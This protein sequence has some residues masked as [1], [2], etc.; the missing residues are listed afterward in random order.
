MGRFQADGPIDMMI[1]FKKEF[2]SLMWVLIVLRIA[3]MAAIIRVLITNY[4]SK[5]SERG[6]YP[7]TTISKIWKSLVVIKNE[8]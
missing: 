6:I 8:Q 4:C 7:A 5:Y 2:P 1:L 3:Y